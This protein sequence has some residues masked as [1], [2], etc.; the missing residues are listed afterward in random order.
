MG[1]E[2]NVTGKIEFLDVEGFKK[3][4]EKI[5]QKRNTEIGMHGDFDYFFT[6]MWGDN[7]E[8]L[9][10]PNREEI[11]LSRQGKLWWDDEKACEFLSKYAKG[12][13]KLVG[14]DNTVWEYV[15]D[16]KG[17]SKLIGER[18]TY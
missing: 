3:D 16:G 14:E 5:A 4:F 10:S 1:Y 6:K 15:L 8:V 7:L 13:I 2:V 12:N 18:S 17:N 9:N 11:T